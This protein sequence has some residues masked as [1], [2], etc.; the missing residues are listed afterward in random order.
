MM[1]STFG[2]AIW[3]TNS[4]A[5]GLRHGLRFEFLAAVARRDMGKRIDRFVRLFLVPP[6]VLALGSLFQNEWLGFLF[7]LIRPPVSCSSSLRDGMDR[8]ESGSSTNGA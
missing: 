8:T 7:S 4:L 2:A 6:P 3:T 5:K 1:V